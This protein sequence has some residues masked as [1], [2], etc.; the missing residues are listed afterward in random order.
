MAENMI[1]LL[2][3][4]VVLLAIPTFGFLSWATVCRQYGEPL[5]WRALFT[6]ISGCERWENRR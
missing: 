3:A 1:Y 5:T 2:A 4:L 6:P